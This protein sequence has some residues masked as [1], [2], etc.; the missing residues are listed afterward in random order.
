MARVSGLR[1]TSILFA[2]VIGAVFL[3]EPFTLRRG[4]SAVLITAGALCLA[5]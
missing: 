2:T 5:G 3:K 1:E 4:A